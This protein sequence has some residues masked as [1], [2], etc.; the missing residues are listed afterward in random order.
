M[1][2]TLPETKIFQ[3]ITHI[4]VAFNTT[5]IGDDIQSEAACRLFDKRCYVNRDDVSNWPKNSLI[6]MI[7]WYSHGYFCNKRDVLFIS[8]HLQD[9]TMIRVS[10]DKKILNWMKSQIKNQKFPALCRDIHTRDFLRDMKIDAEFGGC[11]TSTL[12]S[13]GF[14]RD[15]LLAIDVEKSEDY[16]NYSYESNVS[17]LLPT[18]TP[19]Q[20]IFQACKRIDL[21]DQSIKVITSRLHAYI[22]C[23]ALGVDVELLYNQVTFQPQR[24]TGHITDEKCS[25]NS[26]V[27]NPNS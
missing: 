20:R 5:N 18:M 1:L 22:P 2:F 17:H 25:S 10:K 11:I 13:R 21:Y 14:N 26:L 4:P 6:P 7:G 27:F 12:K 16:K 24:F 23:L 15:K 19:E 9:E 3:E 8:F